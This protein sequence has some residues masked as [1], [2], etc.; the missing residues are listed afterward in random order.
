MVEVGWHKKMLER[1]TG[2]EAMKETGIETG[3]GETTVVK[4][5]S[6]IEKIDNFIN[7]MPLFILCVYYEMI[8]TC[9]LYLTKRGQIPLGSVR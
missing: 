2:K 4:I 1:K 9:Y 7:I 3:S 8:I 6:L 5:Y